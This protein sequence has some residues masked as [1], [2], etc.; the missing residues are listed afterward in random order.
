MYC[1]VG[2]YKVFVCFINSIIHK[3]EFYST[4]MKSIF[5]IEM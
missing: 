5:V 1:Y 4:V 2:V 3:N